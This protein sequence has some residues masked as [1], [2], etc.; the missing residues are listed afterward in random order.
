MNPHCPEEEMLYNFLDDVQIEELD[1]LQSRR[2]KLK[3]GLPVG[4]VKQSKAKKLGD[5][6]DDEALQ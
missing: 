3:A 2:A 4:F 6:S 5:S 1:R